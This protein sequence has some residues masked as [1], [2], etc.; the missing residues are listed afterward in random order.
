[1]LYLGPDGT[2]IEGKEDWLSLELV[3]GQVVFKYDLGSGPASVVCCDGFNFADGKWHQVRAERLVKEIGID[4][5]EE[6]ERERDGDRER[7]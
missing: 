6:R 3:N 1:M 2:K 7:L 4:G 5:D